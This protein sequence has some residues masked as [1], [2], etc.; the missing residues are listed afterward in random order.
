MFDNILKRPT[1]FSKF[2]QS[3]KKLY[4]LKYFDNVFLFGVGLFISFCLS[5]SRTISLGITSGDDGPVLPS[6]SY[7][8]FDLIGENV[9]AQDSLK[10]MWTTSTK[11]LPAICYKYFSI[12]PTIFHSVYT[13]AQITLIIVGV[14]RLASAVSHSRTVAYLAI[15]LTIIYEP[16]FI[17]MGWYGDQFFMPYTTWIAVGP[18]LLAWANLLEGHHKKGMMYLLFGTSIHPSMGVCLMLLVFA[19][20]SN[21]R[22]IT[23]TDISKLYVPVLFGVTVISFLSTL[24]IRLAQYKDPPSTWLALNVAHWEAWKLIS[25]NIFSLSTSYAVVFSI[26]IFALIYNFK[27][28]LNSYYLV[29]IKVFITSALLV[30]IQSIAFIIGLREIYSISLARITIFSSIFLTIISACVID[31]FLSNSN[32]KV[33]RTVIGILI[34]TLL[35]PSFGSFIILLSIMIVCSL[36]KKQVDKF[37]LFIYSLVLIVNSYFYTLS[38]NNVKYSLTNYQLNGDL[39][40]ARTLS[41]RILFHFF[42]NNTYIILFV[43]IFLLIYFVVKRNYQ[44]KRIVAVSLIVLSLVSLMGRLQL[45][46]IR[47]SEHS[48]WAKT[49]EWAKN[50]TDLSSV[51]LT[52]SGLDVYESWSTLSKRIRIIVDGEYGGAYLYSEID[53]A[54]NKKRRLLLLA[55]SIT[56]TAAVQEEFFKDFSNQFGGKY[57]VTTNLNTK[58]KYKI[59]YRNSKYV[60]YLLN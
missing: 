55:P 5:P 38:F 34:C 12:D 35:F 6:I 29:V 37:Q 28:E 57:L 48:E 52:R 14:F 53:D 3:I 36:M 30:L 58:L 33:N 42:S 9:A 17:N 7:K 60:I 1:I 41:L 13:H 46:L 49:Q 18:L 23:R 27:D 20:K 2:M 32:P 56:A 50:N 44:F 59:V 54:F 45:S 47:G 21:F 43:F 8:Y 51:F 26:S 22:N 4:T 25:D 15:G 39:L 19:T 10:M 40:T 11:W 24:P 16:Y 31:Y